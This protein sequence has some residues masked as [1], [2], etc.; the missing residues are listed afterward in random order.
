MNCLFLTSV[1]LTV[2]LVVGSSPGLVAADPLV[3]VQDGQAKATIL[4]AREPGIVTQL[5]AC[6]LQHY[7]KKISGAT[8]PIV[9]EPAE[10]TGTVILV[11]A[12]NATKALGLKNEDFQQREYLLE[13]RPGMLILMGLDASKGG[14]LDYKGGLSAIRSFSWKPL[15]SCH[16]VHT[17]L[18]KYL[19]VRWY[20]PTEIG[21]VVSKRKTIEVPAI[22]IRR[23]T[24]ASEYS[25]N[26]YAIN[27]QLYVHDYTQGGPQGMTLTALDYDRDY[28]LRSG[29]LYWIR[30][31][32]WGCKR[33]G[34]NHSFHGWDKAFGKDHPEW[35]STK[36]WAKM[37]EII[38][39]PWGFQ[40]KINPVLS[41]EGL[42][43]KKIEIIR[44]YFDGKPAP[45][46]LAYG[47]AAGKTF[48][49]ALNDNG[50]W[51][52]DP[53]CLKQ[54]EPQMGSRGK[55]S[56]YFWNFVNRVAREVGKT[57]PEGEII[58]LA[59][60][61]YTLPPKEPFRLEPNVSVM[62][63]RFPIVYWDPDYKKYD[64]NQIETWIRYGA[65]HIYTWEY[66]VWPWVSHSFPAVLPRTYADDGKWLV[67]HP[68]YRG[69]YMQMYGWGIPS[70]D[71]KRKST[72]WENPQFHFFNFYF[73]LKLYDDP[74]LNV[75]DMLNEFYD[76]FYG[77]AAKPARKFVEAME[78][79]WNDR[80]MR[81]ASGFGRASHRVPRK[82]YWEHM[83]NPEFIEKLKRLMADVRAVAP[84][85][86]IYA[87]R[88]D[89]LDKA[90]LGHVLYKRQKYLKS[91]ETTTGS[92]Q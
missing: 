82:L 30:N 23:T 19:G 64:Y 47:T 31:K 26:Q 5:A 68:Q 7:L 13:T 28:D 61:G 71:G 25:R 83:G 49:I 9:R 20:L 67:G 70:K 43:K 59:Y 11:G 73:R 15:G 42:F 17:F 2:L 57:H 44:G 62:L 52:Q 10:V 90:I 33:L 69:G 87:K 3:L 65:K 86:S 22:K 84:E 91:L 76:C 85:G 39:D 40:T 58:G 32:R 54:Y 16:A 18:E 14:E 74:S 77:P 75:Q 36:S 56:R 34:A 60:S 55:V 89:L 27:K 80:Q 24:K 72:V 88:A 46:P 48:G 4:L 81:K 6:E 50:N 38:K 53:R 51:S 79:R 66:L 1:C 45:F 37:Q 8:V 63:C 35:F 92:R 29:V 21:E 12:S 78:D 41:N